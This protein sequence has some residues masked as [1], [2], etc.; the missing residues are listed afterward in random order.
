MSIYTL[1]IDTETKTLSLSYNASFP[2]QGEEHTLTK[3]HIE[4][5]EVERTDA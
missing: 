1:F 5:T 4:V 3:T 2:C